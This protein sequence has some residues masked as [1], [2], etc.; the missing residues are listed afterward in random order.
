MYIKALNKLNEG[1]GNHT[2]VNQIWKKLKQSIK[3]SASEILGY[4]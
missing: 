1:I 4:T 3:K 2:K